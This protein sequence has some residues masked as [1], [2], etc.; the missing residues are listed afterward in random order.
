MLV[1]GKLNG[2]D[3]HN[4]EATIETIK[5]LGMIRM[6]LWSRDTEMGTSSKIRW[7]KDSVWEE[8]WISSLNIGKYTENKEMGAAD[9]TL[10]NCIH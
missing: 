4:R 2:E 10:E 6:L 5:D 9:T 3:I 7:F 1:E 8:L